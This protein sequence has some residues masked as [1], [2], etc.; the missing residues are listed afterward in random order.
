MGHNRKP[1]L[2]VVAHGRDAV[3]EDASC[4]VLVDLL[5]D[6]PIDHIDLSGV[7]TEAVLTAAPGL[8][9]G[10][11]AAMLGRQFTLEI[12]TPEGGPAADGPHTMLRDLGRVREVVEMLS[13]HA[14]NELLY[15]I[16]IWALP[17]GMERTL[18]NAICAYLALGRDHGVFM[19]ALERGAVRTTVEPRSVTISVRCAELSEALDWVREAISTCPIEVRWQVHGD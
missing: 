9:S 10:L 15:P 5:D 7:D 12:H 17:D 1:Y 8:V 6:T 3:S 2:T 11:C 16:S 13:H 4:A 18:S 14:R 19:S